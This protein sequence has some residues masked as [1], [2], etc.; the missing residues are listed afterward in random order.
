MLTAFERQV[1]GDHYKTKIQVVEYCMEN[2][3]GYMESTA[4]KYLSRWEKKGGIED[5]DKAIHYI[6]MLKE[7][8]ERNPKMYGP[9]FTEDNDG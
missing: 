9:E 8:A 4:I 6:E 5:L 1:G 3:I 7:H 2:K